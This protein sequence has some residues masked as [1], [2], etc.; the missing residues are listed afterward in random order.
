MLLP[1]PLVE[2]TGKLSLAIGCGQQGSSRAKRDMSP[3]AIEAPSCA[4]S[5]SYI[6]SLFQKVNVDGNGKLSL[7]EY[8]HFVEKNKRGSAIHL[9]KWIKYFHRYVDRH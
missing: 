7:G 5:G 3:R 4:R 6:D 9:D 8:L 2:V 1:S